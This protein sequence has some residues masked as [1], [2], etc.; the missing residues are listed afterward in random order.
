MQEET[1]TPTQTYNE[2]SVKIPIPYL[3]ITA[4]GS[5]SIKPLNL[6]IAVKIAANDL[7]DALKDAEDFGYGDTKKGAED[8]VKWLYAVHMDLIEET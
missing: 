4:F 2:S 1:R 7:K 5:N 8:F 3:A 6:I